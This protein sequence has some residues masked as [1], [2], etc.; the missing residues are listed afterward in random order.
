VTVAVRY[1]VYTLMP[2]NGTI[3]FLGSF[4]YPG[5]VEVVGLS[6]MRWE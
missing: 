4:N 6:T 3:P 1:R 5:F 2:V